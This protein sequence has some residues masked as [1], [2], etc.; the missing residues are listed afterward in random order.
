M[1]THIMHTPLLGKLYLV[2][3]LVEEVPADRVFGYVDFGDDTRL[4]QGFWLGKGWLDSTGKP[5]SQ[6]I[7]H[8]YHLE[9]PDGTSPF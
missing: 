7:V 2:P 3:H 5:F 9:R 4:V 6:P 8:W 1:K